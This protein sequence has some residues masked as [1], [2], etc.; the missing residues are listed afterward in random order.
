MCI[1]ID[2]NRCFYI[3]NKV[4]V[5]LNAWKVC[6]SAALFNSL[7]ILLKFYR[8]EKKNSSTFSVCSFSLVVAHLKKIIII[9]L[10]GYIIIARTLLPKLSPRRIQFFFFILNKNKTKLYRRRQCIFVLCVH[11]CM[12]MCLFSHTHN[13]KI[14]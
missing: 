4:P 12:C 9:Y 11:F 2:N 10:L 14:Q 5:C 6:F 1:F 3:N 8:T 13:Q 7:E